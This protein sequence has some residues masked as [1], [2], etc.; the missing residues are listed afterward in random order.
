VPLLLPS[1]T[2]FLLPGPQE[3]QLTE[4]IFARTTEAALES[5]IAHLATPFTAPSAFWD[6]QYAQ[7]LDRKARPKAKPQLSWAL[8]PLYA[9]VCCSILL[10]GFSYQP[11]TTDTPAN[12][13]F[14]ITE[15]LTDTQSDELQ[16][17]LEDELIMANTQ[18]HT[19]DPL[20]DEEFLF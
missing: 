10:A 20:V 5:H 9:C 17:L 1:K 19:K 13:S 3:D 18:K 6:T 7:I 14:F 11:Q 4:R 15:A 2:P 8:R 12:T 16:M